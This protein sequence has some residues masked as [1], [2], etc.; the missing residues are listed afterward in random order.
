MKLRC[1]EAEVQTSSNAEVTG[2]GAEKPSSGGAEKL[3][4]EKPG[5]QATERVDV[6]NF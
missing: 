2:G 6:E 5:S 1:S 4:G 3:R